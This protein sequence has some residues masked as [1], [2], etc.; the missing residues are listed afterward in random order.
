MDVNRPIVPDGIVDR[1]TIDAAPL[2]VAWLLKQVQDKEKSGWTSLLEML[3]EI[4][5]TGRIGANASPTWTPVAR[6]SY[7]LLNPELEVGTWWDDSRR[8]LAALDSI[9]VVNVIKTG[10]G[11]DTPWQLIKNEFVRRSE[12]ILREVESVDPDVVI[13]GNVLWAAPWM[14][15]PVPD[16][17]GPPYH[18]YRIG[19]IVWVHA[20]HPQYPRLNRRAYYDWISAAIASPIG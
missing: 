3:R 19:K 12:E 15:H 2:R 11:L 1:A 9:A 10:G 17:P 14:P 16:P 5:R 18:G 13:G 6:V 7:G 4:A 8:Y 20:H